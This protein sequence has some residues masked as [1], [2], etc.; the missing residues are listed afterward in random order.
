M[1]PAPFVVIFGSVST[2][3]TTFSGQT[4][5]DTIV[6]LSVM[7]YMYIFFHSLASHKTAP[8]ENEAPIVDQGGFVPNCGMPSENAVIQAGV[9]ALC[10]MVQ[11]GGVLVAKCYFRHNLSRTMYNQ[12]AIATPQ[13]FE[14][15]IYHLLWGLMN[16]C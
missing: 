9:A 10:A 3:R 7:L 5:G 12:N 14:R 2:V 4:V 11:V 13:I 8:E 1:F 16:C 15:P 6:L